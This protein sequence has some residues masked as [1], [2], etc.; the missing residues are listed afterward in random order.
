MSVTSQSCYSS[1]RREKHVRIDTHQ[2]AQTHP[3]AH[4]RRLLRVTA[5]SAAALAGVVLAGRNSAIARADN[6]QALVGSWFVAATPQG[7]PSAPPRLLVSFTG[8][9]IALRTAPLQQ[10]A[11]PA[12]GTDK[13]FISTTHGAWASNGDGTFGLT[14]AGYVFD[15][16]GK[17]LAMQHIRVAVQVNDSQ[18]G[19]SGPF[20]TEFIGSDG[21]VLASSSGSVEGTRMQVE[22]VG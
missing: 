10:A 7:A 3:S 16:T 12:L 2:I 20:K 15:D 8:D 19:F 9:G 1:T 13:M 21:Q 6:D 17:F 18:D 5:G 22:A 4:R 11:P 14:F